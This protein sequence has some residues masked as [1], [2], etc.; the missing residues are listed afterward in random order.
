MRSETAAGA[1]D[2]GSY[3]VDLGVHLFVLAE[4]LL[5]AALEVLVVLLVLLDQV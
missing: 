5:R 4:A 3:L 1:E 2:L